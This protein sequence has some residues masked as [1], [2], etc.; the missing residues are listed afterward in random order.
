M[1]KLFFILTIV[2]LFLLTNTTV[3]AET[4]ST[5]SKIDL[6]GSTGTAFGKG[7]GR[8]KAVT[9]PLEVSQD[10]TVIYVDFYRSVGDVT[11]ALYDQMGQKVYQSVVVSGY[12]VT[13]VIDTT[14]LP[15][16]MY[17]IVF[18]NTSGMNLEGNF[19]L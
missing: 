6:T 13:E 11:V 2:G 5:A 15:E 19:V 1:K 8:S 4:K 10:A 7:P 12:G 9:P 3:G 18:T 14:Y 16:G 17:K